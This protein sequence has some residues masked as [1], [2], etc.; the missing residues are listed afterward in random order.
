MPE[1]D[2]IHRLAHRI[3]A[4]CQ[5]QMIS[6]TVARQLKRSDRLLNARLK[7]ASAT[8]KHLLLTLDNGLII[9]SHLGREGGWRIQQNSRI[10]PPRQSLRLRLS[11]QD[12]SLDCLNTRTLEVLTQV[13]LKR[14]DVL[15]RLG[16]DILGPSLDWD[17][18]ATRLR[19]YSPMTLGEMLLQQMITSGIGNVY[20]SDVLFLEK[21]HPLTPPESLTD[22]ELRSLFERA[23][24]LMQRNL[25]PGP[26]RTRWS[27]GPKLWVYGRAGS[28]CLICGTLIE[29]FRQGQPPR[30]TYIC[31]TCQKQ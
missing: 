10:K 8:G 22:S 27:P 6:Q 18:V 23:R 29:R 14:H 1:G 12:V 25:G 21:K 2:S 20:K 11:F 17:A 7:S 4:S 30:S 3:N 24:W 13:E 16:P 26:R 28:P 15:R 19:T 31:P 5:G 9:H